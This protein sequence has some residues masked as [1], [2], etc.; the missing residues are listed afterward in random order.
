RKQQTPM[1]QVLNIKSLF[2]T[3]RKD[4]EPVNDFSFERR[5][6]KSNESL[7]LSLASKQTRDLKSSEIAKIS[8]EVLTTFDVQIKKLFQVHSVPLEIKSSFEEDIKELVENNTYSNNTII[9]E[10]NLIKKSYLTTILINEEKDLDI[11]DE[12][13]LE[14]NLYQQCIIQLAYNQVI[15]NT[16]NKTTLRN[17]VKNVIIDK[18]NFESVNE[19]IN[20]VII[21]FEQTNVQVQSPKIYNFTSNITKKYVSEHLI[22][23]NKFDIKVSPYKHKTNKELISKFRSE[24]YLQNL[25]N[26][27]MHVEKAPSTSMITSTIQK[28]IT[29]NKIENRIE[30]K[31]ENKIE[32]IYKNILQE[33][34]INRPYT[35]L[36]VIDKKVVLEK[37][38]KLLQMKNPTQIK[39]AYE[40]IKNEYINESINHITNA[41][42]QN[43]LNTTVENNIIINKIETNSENKIE[44]RYTTKVDNIYKNILQEI[45]VNRPYTQLSV[46]DKKVILEKINKLV[47]M[48]N[49]TQIN[50]AYE[51]IKNEYINQ[52]VNTTNIQNI[53]NTTLENNIIANKIETKTETKIENRQETSVDNIY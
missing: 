27:V 41:T 24:T 35:Q 28:N 11:K 52:S 23:I 2:E 31:F 15:V 22:S 51:S 48:K 14:Q 37:I 17:I 5:L 4:F 40:N 3:S 10:L 39:T 43:I 33:I 9:N 34:K 19:I 42:I 44:N 53:L 46:I 8:T 49:H 13:N 45:K 6:K 36:S 12:Q 18:E 25:I 32:N 47:Q 21:K 20:E 16:N 38:N 30:N 7:F 29:E 26:T 1:S 50:I